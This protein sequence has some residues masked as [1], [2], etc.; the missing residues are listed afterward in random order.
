MVHAYPSMETVAEIRDAH[1]ARVL[2][3]SLAPDGEMVV[4]AAADENLKFWKIWETPP[5]KKVEKNR[6][7]MNND[8]ILALR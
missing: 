1:D 5:K 7:I 6:G 8:S 3:S 2:Y 4:T